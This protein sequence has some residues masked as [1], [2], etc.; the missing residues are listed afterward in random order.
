MKKSSILVLFVLVTSLLSCAPKIE[1]EKEN[2]EIVYT[3][4]LY[5]VLRGKLINEN[6]SWRIGSTVIDP[7]NIKDKMENL[8]GSKA[9]LWGYWGHDG[10][11]KV[12]VVLSLILDNL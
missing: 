7:V 5:G 6:G 4:P 12:F 10:D 11:R 3:S 8:E 1:G 2:P 9:I